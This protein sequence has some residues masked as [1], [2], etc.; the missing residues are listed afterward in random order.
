MCNKFTGEHPCRSVISIKLLCSFI[1]IA[2]RHECSVNLLHIFRTPFPKNT[3]GVQVSPIS[4]FKKLA[5]LLSVWFLTG[6]MLKIML[7]KDTNA[8]NV[9]R[10]SINLLRF[11]I[12]NYM[13]FLSSVQISFQKHQI[14]N[15]D[16]IFHYQWIYCHEVF[17]WHI[18]HDAVGNKCAGMQ[19]VQ[20]LNQ[21]EFTGICDHF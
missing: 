1:E 13:Y 5:I 21:S 15:N 11:S 2:L 14:N 12:I 17:W 18:L 7:W 16:Y 10:K 3:Y 20:S 6:I 8:W 9:I 4:W 19:T